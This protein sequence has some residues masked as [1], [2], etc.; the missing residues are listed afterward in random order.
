MPTPYGHERLSRSEPERPSFSKRTGAALAPEDL[1]P[2]LH[3]LA[4]SLR[5]NNAHREC[6]GGAAPG[7]R[8]HRNPL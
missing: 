1:L 6:G 8:S 2:H 4:R 3:G 7:R 5:E